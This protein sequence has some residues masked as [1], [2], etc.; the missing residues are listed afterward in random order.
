MSHILCVICNMTHMNRLFGRPYCHDSKRHGMQISQ[1]LIFS[2]GILTISSVTTCCKSCAHLNYSE[3]DLSCGGGIKQ[4]NRKCKNG[5]VGD[6]GCSPYMQVK[7][8]ECNSH[9][10]ST[11]T[12]TTST[13]T[14]TQGYQYFCYLSIKHDCQ[15]ISIYIYIR[16]TIFCRNIQTAPDSKSKNYFSG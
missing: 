2:F 16:Y 14:T 3:C 15:S 6:A 13:T 7:V 11:T 8:V 12:T 10:C 5:E 9:M 4:C 1:I